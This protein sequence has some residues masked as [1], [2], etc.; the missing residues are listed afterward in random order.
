MAE[1]K[2]GNI[3]KFTFWAIFAMII[4]GGIVYLAWNKGDSTTTSKSSSACNVTV[5]DGTIDTVDKL[6]PNEVKFTADNFDKEVIQAK[7]VVLVDAYAPWCPHCQ[8]ISTAISKLADDYA[9]KVKIGT[10]N[11]NNQDPATKA[12]FDFAVAKGLQGYPTIWI[13]KDGKV[14]D[15]FSGEKTYCQ[16]K[17]I[18]DKQ[19]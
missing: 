4:I 9:G 17:A 16:I 14:V 1:E 10:L 5:A 13:Y 19:L 6:G 15:S 18:L 8:R 11:A 2:Q 7:G 12:N 3:W